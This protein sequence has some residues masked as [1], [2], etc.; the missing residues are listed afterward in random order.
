MSDCFG[1]REGVR[2]LTK[3]LARRLKHDYKAR[4]RRMSTIHRQSRNNGEAEL[5]TVM[6]VFYDKWKNLYNKRRTVCVCVCMYPSS[7]HSFGPIGM[8]LGMDTPW[9]PG[10]DMG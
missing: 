10:S 6:L 3:M 5:G 4:G 9:D 7:A 8:K 2:R 1:G